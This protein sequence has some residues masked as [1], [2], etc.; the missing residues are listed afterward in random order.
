MYIGVLCMC[1]LTT[2]AAVNTLACFWL[3]DHL[4][5]DGVQIFISFLIC[6]IDLV[7]EELPNLSVKTFILHSSLR[8]A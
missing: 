3:Y 5:A 8:L 4:I 7:L 1:V 6:L 2:A